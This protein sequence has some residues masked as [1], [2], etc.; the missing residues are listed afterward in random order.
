MVLLYWS[1]K[2]SYSCCHWITSHSALSSSLIWSQKSYSNGILEYLLFLPNKTL[3]AQGGC[4]ICFPRSWQGFTVL[5]NMYFLMTFSKSRGKGTKTLVSMRSIGWSIVSLAVAREC[6][7][8]AKNTY[9]SRHLSPEGI[10]KRRPHFLFKGFMHLL[11]A[12]W[13]PRVLLCTT[14]SAFCKMSAH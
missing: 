6:H 9:F 5:E 10:K 7:Q 14:T 4:V 12:V 3:F 2:K 11:K 1:A 8:N 13:V